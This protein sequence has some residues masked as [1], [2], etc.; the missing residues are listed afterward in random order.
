[1]STRRPVLPKLPRRSRVHRRSG[2]AWL[3]NQLGWGERPPR[4][5]PLV[6]PQR[7]WPGS[8]CGKARQAVERPQRHDFRLD[9]SD[10]DLK[11]ES[12]SAYFRRRHF[13]YVRVCEPLPVFKCP[14]WLREQSANGQWNL[15]APT[16]SVV[17]S[18]TVEVM[19]GSWIT[20]GPLA[21]WIRSSVLV[22]PGGHEQSALRVGRTAT[23]RMRS[24]HRLCPG[25][26]RG[27]WRSGQRHRESVRDR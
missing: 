4:P 24:V 14:Q 16:R 10:R 13:V 22:R 19:A 12:F 1:M 2:Q 21:P 25:R 11:A 18:S 17:R 20:A 9:L 23:C 5:D 6:L 3:Y 27:L 8:C 26:C 7:R 15:G